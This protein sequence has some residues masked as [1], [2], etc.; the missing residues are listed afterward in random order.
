M[1]TRKTFFPFFQSQQEELLALELII[2]RQTRVY[3]EHTTQYS[4][5]E[6]CFFLITSGDSIKMGKIWERRC[7]RSCNVT[8]P[9]RYSTV[10]NAL[11]QA[12]CAHLLIQLYG[13][14]VPLALLLRGPDQLHPVARAWAARVQPALHLAAVVH[15][16]EQRHRQT[17][18]VSNFKV[19][20]MPME[21]QA[22]RCERY[23]SKS[24]FYA[25]KRLRFLSC[26][27][28]STLMKDPSGNLV[29]LKDS[30]PRLASSCHV[31]RPIYPAK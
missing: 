14:H 5:A 2:E 31:P 28:T 10:H 6:L 3:G 13:H 26:H 9:T 8:A 18:A 17:A 15:K 29:S 24:S 1:N 23:G 4:W 21:S 16:L 25:G 27:E 22:Y 30:N 11:K 19:T 20:V 7:Y 12:L